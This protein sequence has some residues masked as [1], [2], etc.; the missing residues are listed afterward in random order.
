MRGVIALFDL[1]FS[2]ETADHC[3]FR[4]RAERCNRI[5]HQWLLPPVPAEDYASAIRLADG[6]QFSKKA[7]GMIA[8][9]CP[10]TAA[11]NGSNCLSCN[12]VDDGHRRE[13]KRSLADK[14]NMIRI[15]DSCLGREYPFRSEGRFCP[16][17]TP[18]TR[19]V[20]MLVTE[21]NNPQRSWKTV[22]TNLK[23][24]RDY[25]LVNCRNQ[26]HLSSSQSYTWRIESCK[27]TTESRIV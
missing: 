20:E 18:N 15:A 27:R 19:T 3:R 1:L 23:K 25:L 13:G 21:K 8:E 2:P 12:D 22:A 4:N 14:T 7:A 26:R 9:G 11:E 16:T 10:A 17:E 24:L 6:R 5:A